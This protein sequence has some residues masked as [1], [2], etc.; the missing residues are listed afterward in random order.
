MELGTRMPKS[1]AKEIRGVMGERILPGISVHAH[2][3]DSLLFQ[4]N[5]MIVP[6][7]GPLGLVAA[8]PSTSKTVANLA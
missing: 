7:L 5:W 3:M 1:G 4:L 8:F 2:G 6:V